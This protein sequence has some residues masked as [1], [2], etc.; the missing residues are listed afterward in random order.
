MLEENPTD[1]PQSIRSF[2]PFTPSRAA[3]GF[4]HL[5]A[6]RDLAHDLES[7]FDAVRCSRLRITSEIIDLILAG[8][9]ALKQFTREIGAQLQGTNAGAPILV[10]TQQIIARVKSVSSR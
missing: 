5:D 7:L 3:A 2:A 8:A 1:A 9:D 6:M 10:P 4:L